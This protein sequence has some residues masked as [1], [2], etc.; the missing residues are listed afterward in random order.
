[1]SISK[2]SAA[3]AIPL[4]KPLAS[5]S[6]TRRVGQLIFVAGQGCRD[7]NTNAYRGLTL[8]TDGA[9]VSYDIREQARGVLENIERA[10]R[11][12]GLD[13]SAIVDVQVF[14]TD[15][16]DFPGMNEVWNEFFKEVSPLPTRTT[17]AVKSLPG[18]NFVEMKTVAQAR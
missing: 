16:K 4:T 5:Y 9:V 10:L 17:V 14:L 1:M 3:G 2:E 15:M 8:A 6:H 7:P 12:E 13:R 11:S 18:T